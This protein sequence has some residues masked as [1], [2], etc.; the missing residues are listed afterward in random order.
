MHECLSDIVLMFPAGIFYLLIRDLLENKLDSSRIIIYVTGSI[1]VL[2]AVAVTQHIQ[3]NATFLSTY[4]ESGGRRTAIAEKLRKLPLS[5]FGKKDLSDLTTNIMSDCARME[6]ASSHWIPELIGSVIATFIIG[7]SRL[8]ALFD[9]RLALTSFWVISVSFL[10]LMTSSGAQKKVVKKNVEV[11]LSL[12]D[13]IQECLE[14][15]RDLRANHAEERY[16]EGK[17]E[18]RGS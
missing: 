18:H 15:V 8:F 1:V 14:S 12:S 6:T 2:L 11:Q 4:K 13:G 9:W 3:Y 17:K 7:I 10:V 16:M 5:Y